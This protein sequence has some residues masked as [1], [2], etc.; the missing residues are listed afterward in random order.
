MRWIGLAAIS[1]VWMLVTE[2]LLAQPASQFQEPGPPHASMVSQRPI[3]APSGQSSVPM[4]MVEDL[5]QT[6]ADQSQIINHTTDCEFCQTYEHYDDSCAESCPDGPLARFK[7][8]FS[9]HTPLGGASACDSY[10]CADCYSHWDVEKRIFLG[11]VNGNAMKPATRVS[12]NDFDGAQIAMEVLP[13]VLQDGSEVFSRWGFTAMY[14]YSNFYGSRFSQAQ[15]DFSGGL[16]SVDGGD[17]HSFVFGATYRIDFDMIWVRF[18][19]NATIGGTMDWVDLDQIRGQGGFTYPVE[20]FRWTGFDCG[21]YT[22]LMFDFGITESLNFGLGMDFRASSTDVMMDEDDLR[23][24]M[25][26]VIGLS[27]TF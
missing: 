8:R 9:S 16:A 19:P 6:E 12:V 13:W 21:F 7:R 18:S 14:Q 2:P 25:G 15:S 1:A 24:H 27:H 26:F 17:M 22:R 11:Y 20:S 5:Q 10:P 23:K 3:F 4:G